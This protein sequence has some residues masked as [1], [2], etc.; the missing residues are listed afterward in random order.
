MLHLSTGACCWYSTRNMFYKYDSH[1]C[2]PCRRP[3]IDLGKDAN[4]ELHSRRRPAISPRPAAIIL[5]CS[6]RMHAFRPFCFLS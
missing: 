5:R 4:A 2:V 1:A 6:L 3:M